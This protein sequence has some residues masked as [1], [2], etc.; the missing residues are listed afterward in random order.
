MVLQSTVVISIYIRKPLAK[1]DF[2]L[3]TKADETQNFIRFFT[4]SE[5]LSWF[6]ISSTGS[7]VSCSSLTACLTFRSYFLFSGEYVSLNHCISM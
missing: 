1:L 3:T 6:I 2:T 5:I 4:S 7:A